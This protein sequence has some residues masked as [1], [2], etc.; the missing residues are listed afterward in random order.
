MPSPGQE[1]VAALPPP[2]HGGFTAS[3]GGSALSGIGQ[4]GLKATFTVRHRGQVTA[5]RVTH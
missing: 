1:R 4:C 5:L 2:L 3:E